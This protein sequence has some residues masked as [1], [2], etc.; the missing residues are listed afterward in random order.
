MGVLVDN[1]ELGQEYV[2]GVQKI[3]LNGEVNAESARMV[4]EQM[5]YLDSRSDEDIPRQTQVML[6]ALRSLG[7]RASASGRNGGS[8]LWRSSRRAAGSP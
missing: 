6:N 3:Y 1:I 8:P 5:A 7:I 4:M 2:D